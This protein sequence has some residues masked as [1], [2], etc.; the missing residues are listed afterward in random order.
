M[1]DSCA[2]SVCT[3]DLPY[4]SSDVILRSGITERQGNCFYDLWWV[5]SEYLPKQAVARCDLM[6]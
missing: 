1:D 4:R 6:K 5:F 3:N 2:L